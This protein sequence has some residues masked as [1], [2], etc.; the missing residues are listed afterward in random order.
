MGAR[1]QPGV[2]GFPGPKGANVS[3]TVWLIVDS[4][5]WLVGC[6]GWLM[7]GWLGVFNDLMIGWLGVLDDWW[8]VDWVFWMIYIYIGRLHIY[9][10]RVYVYSTYNWTLLV[11][12]C[13][14][15]VFWLGRT[16]QGRRERIARCARSESK[17]FISPRQT[18]TDSL[19]SR[20]MWNMP[21]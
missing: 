18:D 17:S 12:D 3:V 20:A 5:L 13:F 7:I 16:W 2:M 10:D 15:C 9:M 6:F 4:L 1:G 21:G 11:A 8:L 19:F 14:V